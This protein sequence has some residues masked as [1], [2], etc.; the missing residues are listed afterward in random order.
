MSI[1]NIYVRDISL[2]Y[3]AFDSI[4]V[5]PD[6]IISVL[7]MYIIPATII[8]RC[9]LNY[10]IIF[11]GWKIT[12]DFVDFSRH[13]IWDFCHSEFSHSKVYFTFRYCWSREVESASFCNFRTLQVV[14]RLSSLRGIHIVFIHWHAP[15]TLDVQT[16]TEYGK[17]GTNYFYVRFTSLSINSKHERPSS[18]VVNK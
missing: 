11:M 12:N 15:Y 5:L 8:D 14:S 10:I 9:P 3:N 4:N 2:I 17:V 13:K 1:L 18:E 7:Q 16:C 6:I